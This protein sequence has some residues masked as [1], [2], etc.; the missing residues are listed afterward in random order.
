MARKK[1]LRTINNNEEYLSQGN[2][3]EPHAEFTMESEL[4]SGGVQVVI[5]GT[6]FV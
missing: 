6:Y 3:L 1:R 2:M 4:P 5:E